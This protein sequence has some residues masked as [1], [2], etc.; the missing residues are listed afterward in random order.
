MQGY[1]GLVSS[2]QS[3]IMGDFRRHCT[4]ECNESVDRNNECPLCHRCL[5]EYSLNITA[6]LNLHKNK[7]ETLKRPMV[8]ICQKVRTYFRLRVTEI[9]KTQCE[10]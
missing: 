1:M 4:E 3:E 9:C 2:T 7:F 5:W 8:N 10:V 6:K